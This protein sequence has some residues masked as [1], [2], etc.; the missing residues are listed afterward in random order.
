MITTCRLRFAR[1]DFK[2]LSEHLFPGDNDEHG[3]VLLA[4][5]SQL[6]IRPTFYVREVH[7]A[8]EGVDYVE[9]KIGYRAL[10]PKFIHRLITRARDEHLA[11]LA[12]HNHGSDLEVGFSSIDYA[13]HELGYPALLQIARGM[14]VGA[15]VFGHRS[16]QADIWLPAGHR[17]ELDEAV[18]VGNT[19]ERLTSSR[20]R[21]FDD[22]SDSHDR[23][24]RMFGKVGQARLARCRVGIIGLGGI[25]SLVAEYLA[26]LGIG[27]FL[28]I[29]DD[30][31]EESNL[32]RIV[33]ASP[34]D[35]ERSVE[36]VEV[37]RRLIL[38]GNPNAKIE[39]VASD[40]AKESVARALCCC[41]YLF[42]AAD[43][44]RARLVFNAV[45]HQYFIP[46]VQMGSKIRSGKNGELDDVMSAKRPVRPGLGCLWCSQLID[47]NRLAVEAK[48]DEERRSQAYGVEEPNPSVVTLNA[49]SAA[50]AVNDF[51][52]DYL[53]LRAETDEL[54]Y[55]EFHFLSGKRNLV[56]PR[57]DAEC[58][59]CS[60]TGIRYGRADAVSLPCIEG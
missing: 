42:L 35:A 50:H 57:Q 40:V 2:K 28:L 8:E 17:L 22:K 32:S 36:K 30:R 53:R 55:E 12:V 9:G 4:G 33:G 23:Q 19:I 58:P 25:G 11:Y 38:Q 24:I 51:L 26:R 54:Y 39:T 5:Y 52:L 10:S 43:S 45:V 49:I 59:E 44:M 13:S 1:S 60:R 48:T 46:G 31:V 47:A 21:S 29:D 6:E 27:S 20:A 7:L 18:V 15:L 3:A 37:A 34:G 41:D 56:K 14:P 16:V